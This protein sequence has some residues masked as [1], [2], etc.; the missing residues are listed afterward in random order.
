LRWGWGWV[1]WPELTGAPQL[2]CVV[3]WAL[4]CFVLFPGL[5][6]F[7]LFL[8]PRA[9]CSLRTRMPPVW[10]LPT[11]WWCGTTPPEPSKVP[12]QFGRPHVSHPTPTSHTLCPTMLAAEPCPCC[13][14]RPES[15]TCTHHNDH[16][17]WPM[18][19][20]R[21]CVSFPPLSA[22]SYD[23]MYAMGVSQYGQMTAGSY[24]YI[25]PQVGCNVFLPS[26]SY[27][28]GRVQQAAGTL[29]IPARRLYC[30]GNQGIV[31]GT[32]LTLLSASRKYLH[33]SIMAGKVFVSSGLGG[34]SGAQAKAAVVCGAVG[35]IAEVARACRSV[36]C[37]HPLSPA[38]P[39]QPRATHAPPLFPPVTLSSKAPL[40]LTPLPPL[41]PLPP[42]PRPP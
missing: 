24:C 14:L 5:P 28:A 11:A 12:A 6:L 21:P 9:V 42:P 19:T 4:L 2:H 30:C 38:P 26:P 41:P 34:M 35:V 39:L 7:A 32:T 10:W 17:H 29:V 40:P 23:R 33:T 3:S 31:H 13:V 37:S 27:C 22:S 20:H 1:H 8:H 25:G 18:P 36:A 16:H 15:H